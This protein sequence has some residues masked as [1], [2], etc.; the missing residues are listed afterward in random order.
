MLEDLDDSSWRYLFIFSVAE[1]FK[2]CVLFSLSSAYFGAVSLVRERCRPKSFKVGRRRS[3]SLKRVEPF[4]F[5]V[6][7]NLDLKQEEPERE[8][9]DAKRIF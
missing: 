8:Y 2:V 7:E 3:Q 4:S 5:E 9:F 1:D 6:K